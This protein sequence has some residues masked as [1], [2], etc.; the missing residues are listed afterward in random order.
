MPAK[1]EAS[2]NEDGSVDRKV[3]DLSFDA[4]HRFV[5]YFSLGVLHLLLGCVTTDNKQTMSKQTYNK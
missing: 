5:V 4:V 2:Q 3:E 1:V